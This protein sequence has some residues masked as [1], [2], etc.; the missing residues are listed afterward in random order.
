MT[1]SF[2]YKALEWSHEDE[3]RFVRSGE[4]VSS[5]PASNLV[6]VYFG[7]RCSERDIDYIERLAK[8]SACDPHLAMIVP[9]P[10]SGFEMEVFYDEDSDRYRELARTRVHE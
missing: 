2:T 1:Q 8:R 9:K 5:F 7:Y 10:G 3:Y 4:G 6:S